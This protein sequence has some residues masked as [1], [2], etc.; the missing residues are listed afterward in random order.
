MKLLLHFNLVKALSTYYQRSKMAAHPTMKRVFEFSTNIQQELIRST[1]DDYS[2][3]HII[4]RK[5]FVLHCYLMKQ[6]IYL[7]MSYVFD[8]LLGCGSGFITFG[9]YKQLEPFGPIISI[10]VMAIVTYILGLNH[11]F[12]N[13]FW[14]KTFQALITIVFMAKNGVGIKNWSLLFMVPP[15]TYDSSAV[16]L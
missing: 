16:F 2:V 5:A 9:T 8:C 14:S 1:S 7:V 3:F 15:I 13:G 4:P 6:K 12:Y 11:F 10:P